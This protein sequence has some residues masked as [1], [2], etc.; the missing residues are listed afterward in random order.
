MAIPP[1]PMA[2]PPTEGAPTLSHGVGHPWSLKRP[3]VAYTMFY[4]SGRKRSKT[5][6]EDSHL[7]GSTPWFLLNGAP[8]VYPRLAPTN[9]EKRRIIDKNQNSFFQMSLDFFKQII[10]TFWKELIG[11]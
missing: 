4:H 3:E 1:T 9:Q 11:P 10:L 7:V 6:P 5:Q 8:L 2:I